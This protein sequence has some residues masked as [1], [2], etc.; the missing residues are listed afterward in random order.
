MNL[1]RGIG[2]ADL[3]ILGALGKFNLSGPQ[4]YSCMQK[5][6]HN[7]GQFTLNINTIHVCTYSTILVQY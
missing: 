5:L 3:S 2:R 1:K 6:L 4:S 7:I